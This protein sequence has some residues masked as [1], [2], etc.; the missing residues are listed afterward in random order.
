[1]HAPSIDE[2]RARAAE[3]GIHPTDADLERVQGF[4]AILLPQLEELERRVPADATPAAVY[5]PE[6]ER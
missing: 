1:V 6:A 5:R 2:L 4:L 3:Q